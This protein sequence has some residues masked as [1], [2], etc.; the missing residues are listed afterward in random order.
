MNQPQIFNLYVPF[1]SI[2]SIS[3]ILRTNIL[4]METTNY[5]KDFTGYE[6][7]NPAM[8]CYSKYDP[9]NKTFKYFENPEFS[10]E[11]Q[12]GY[13][14]IY[15][16]V[17][18]DKCN[19]PKPDEYYL[20]VTSKTNF[21]FRHQAQDLNINYNVLYNLI[22]NSIKLNQGK[23]M[24]NDEIFF[25]NDNNYN[26]TGLGIKFINNPFNDCYQK[27][28]FPE[29]NPENMVVIYPPDLNSNSE[30]IVGPNNS[31]L[32]IFG[33]KLNSNKEG[34]FNIKYIFK[35]FKYSPNSNIKENKL[36]LSINFH[37]FC[38]SD[39]KEENIDEKYYQYFSLNPIL[40][41]TESSLIIEKDELV[42]KL[43]QKYPEY[44]KKINQLEIK[45]SSK[46][47]SLLKFKELNEEEGLYIG[48]VNSSD[49]KNGR[50]AFI[51]H[52]S[53][54]SKIGY[55]DNNEMKG[56]GSEYD[57]NMNKIAEGNYENGKMNG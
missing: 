19:E 45:L 12:K 23:F 13:Y 54:N 42:N 22:F 40:K 35:T 29:I 38:S 3:L 52:E 55:W 27:W 33:I 24:K 41:E 37:E 57:K 30:L 1:K 49:E 39:I 8:I 51:L 17:L 11:L 47:N 9:D 14:I 31:H 34:K 15:A 21:K 26:F 7:I 10:R 16:W 28:T 44:M 18:Y 56:E 25:M 32:L 6:K 5:E 48:Q 36:P 43:T 20:K 4:D 50:G 46:E 2:V 53:Q